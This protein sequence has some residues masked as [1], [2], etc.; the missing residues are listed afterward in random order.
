VTADVEPRPVALDGL[1]LLRGALGADPT[2]MSQKS[3][4]GE[5]TAS[6]VADVLRRGIVLG[7]LQPGSALPQELALTEYFNVSRPTLREAFRILEAER[8]LEIRRGVHG[9]PYIRR[10]ESAVAATY[11]GLMLQMDGVL[12]Q[13]VYQARSVMEAPAARLLAEKR[14]PAA[15]A[16]LRANLA[17]AESV[18]AGDE[19][20][21]AVDMP[22]L[23]QE[24]HSLLVELGGN[25]TLHLF[26]SMIEHIVAL[27]S[28]S[29]VDA[30]HGE[31][32]RER[33]YHYALRSHTRLVDLIEE[34]EAEAVDAVWRSH[35]E[36]V[37]DSLLD[38][39]PAS[40][41]VVDL[42]S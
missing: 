8:L 36:Q 26:D 34:G 30:Q 24:F 19:D 29:Y 23:S 9:G 22:R 11:A 25:R 21:A 28:R 27:G 1:E 14:D 10:P 37:A 35:L 20:R 2:D 41:R 42:L 33:T 7:R 40:G 39:N 18:L 31:A 13:D 5:K 12:L 17:E 15:I 4:R 6:R 32:G 3:G 16:R 38:G